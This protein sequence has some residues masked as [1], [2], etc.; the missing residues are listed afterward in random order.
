[1]KRSPPGSKSCHLGE[2][3]IGRTRP[4]DTALPLCMWYVVCGGKAV[5]WDRVLSV[6][7][8]TTSSSRRQYDGGGGA[9]LNTCDCRLH[10]PS[11]WGKIW[12]YCGVIKSI[13]LLDTIV[14]S[15]NRSSLHS[16]TA[17][18]VRMAS[19]HFLH[20]IRASL[21]VRNLMFVRLIFAC[22][23][24]IKPRVANIFDKRGGCSQ[25]ATE[26]KNIIVKRCP[27]VSTLC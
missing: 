2:D 18:G 4:L 10:F 16:M 8:S 15:Q 7:S 12:W 27:W 6:R 26:L 11:V 3:V 14:L 17:K 1:M 24:D 21:Y 22:C 20:K 9:C 23:A 13:S 25:L 19:T 5:S